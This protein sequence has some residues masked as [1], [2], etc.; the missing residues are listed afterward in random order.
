MQQQP[1][2][3][4][5]PV[6]SKVVPVL[7]LRYCEFRTASQDYGESSPEVTVCATFASEVI[8]EMSF[9]SPHGEIIINALRMLKEGG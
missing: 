6:P 3:Q 8:E 5:E 4:P 2:A 1:F 7:P 9:C